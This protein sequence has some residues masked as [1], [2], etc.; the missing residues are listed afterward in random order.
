MGGLVGQCRAAREV[1]FGVGSWV[2]EAVIMYR[3]SVRTLWADNGPKG[4]KRPLL[5]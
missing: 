3:F 5:R 1:P 4:G 2:A